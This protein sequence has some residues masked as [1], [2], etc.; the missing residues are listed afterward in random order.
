MFNM[1]YTNIINNRIYNILKQ[2]NININDNEF[3]KI[4]NKD[5]NYIV[6][7]FVKKKY[8]DYNTQKCVV[9]RISNKLIQIDF[10]EKINPT[11]VKLN[12]KKVNSLIRRN[13][14]NLT[15]DEKRIIN[16]YKIKL[17]DNPLSINDLKNTKL[18]NI[19]LDSNLCIQDYEFN[20]K[21]DKLTYREL[22]D[23]FVDRQHEHKEVRRMIK[24]KINK[25][26]TE[27]V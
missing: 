27:Y 19:L 17:I 2:S 12:E 24:N 5:I 6:N 8:N 9:E 13:Y 14:S 4:K 11:L 23:Y 3:N 20:E 25:H 10:P 1:R 18:Y 16:H 7:Y 26:L 15:I 22:I 21:V